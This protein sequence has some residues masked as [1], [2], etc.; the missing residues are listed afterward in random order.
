VDD[1]AGSAGIPEPGGVGSPDLSR[2]AQALPAGLSLTADGG[3]L[4]KALG[5]WRVAQGLSRYT[6]TPTPM[7]TYAVPTAT[8]IPTP[9]VSPT[10][11]PESA[12]L[13]GSL[14]DFFTFGGQKKPEAAPAT[15][16][17]RGP[18]R[19][20]LGALADLFT[21]GSNPAP[22]PVPTPQPGAQAGP[23][24]EPVITGPT[25]LP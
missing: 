1:E 12:G 18:G 23:T 11:V 2:T 19:G 15:V 8:P 13:L 9:Q 5:D 25:M 6:P 3:D 14:L 7:P 10:P 24:P 17:Q 20:L 21:F 16:P 22:T 4:D